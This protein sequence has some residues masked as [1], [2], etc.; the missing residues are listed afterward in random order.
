MKSMKSKSVAPKKVKGPTAKTKMS[1]PKNPKPNDPAGE[2]LM[3]EGQRRLVMKGVKIGLPFFGT[4]VGI[5]V[6]AVTAKSEEA[7]L[8]AKGSRQ[9][10]RAGRKE[11][12]SNRLSNRAEEMVETRPMKAGRLENRSANLKK[13]ASELRSKGEANKKAAEKIYNAKQNKKKS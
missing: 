7:K 6:P 10:N 8:D 12:R 1:G 9:L 3:K 5:G 11:S 4:T 2:A 13:K